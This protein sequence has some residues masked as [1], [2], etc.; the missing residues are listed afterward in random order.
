MHN[1]KLRKEN[2][3]TTDQS[4]SELIVDNCTYGNHVAE[5]RADRELMQGWHVDQIGFR[6]ATNQCR[7]NIIFEEIWITAVILL[8]DMFEFESIFVCLLVIEW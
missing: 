1:Q 2:E 4:G 6:M 5:L 7:L 3:N 8:I